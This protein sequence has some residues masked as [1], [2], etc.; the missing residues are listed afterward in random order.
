MCNRFVKKLPAHF[1]GMISFSRRPVHSSAERN[2]LRLKPKVGEEE[3][4]ECFTSS[5]LYSSF[6][7]CIDNVS[8][9]T[10]CGSS[11]AAYKFPLEEGSSC[12]LKLTLI[13]YLTTRRRL[14]QFLHHVY[15]KQASTCP[16]I[17]P[18]RVTEGE[19]V[20]T[21]ACC[22]PQAKAFHFGKSIPSKGKLKKWTEFYL[23]V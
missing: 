10:E 17:Q 23:S 9:F 15:G 14:H 5:M 1:P 2:L 3:S 19:E 21:S 7:R 4:E 12:S 22:W 6:S 8:A 16:V 11:C 13:N 20:M 18:H